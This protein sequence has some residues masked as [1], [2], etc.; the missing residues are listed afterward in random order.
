[1]ENMEPKVQIQRS[2]RP[3]DLQKQEAL[4]AEFDSVAV[5]GFLRI[6]DSDNVFVLTGSDADQSL[7]ISIQDRRRLV[8]PLGVV[9]HHQRRFSMYVVSPHFFETLA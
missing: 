8:F 2:Q 5:G 7:C 4:L 3:E 9:E 1:M 6:P